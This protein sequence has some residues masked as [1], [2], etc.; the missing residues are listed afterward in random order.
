[1]IFKKH[2]H[3]HTDIKKS[4]AFAEAIPRMGIT[5]FILYSIL[6][7]LEKI[8]FYKN[9]WYSKVFLFGFRSF[10]FIVKLYIGIRSQSVYSCSIN[11][12]IGLT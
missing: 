9:E 1:M 5:S 10:A 8:M 6:K 12:G 2:S 7:G 4:Q 11:R 3:F